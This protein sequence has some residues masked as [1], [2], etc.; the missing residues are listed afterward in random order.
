MA[1][2]QQ[3]RNDAMLFERM[4]N[5]I[6]IEVLSYMT[7][8]NAVIAFSTLN[9]R[10]QSLLIE[11]CHRFNFTSV[12]KK[13]FDI[14]FQNQDTNR[15]RSL[16]LHDG[17]YTPGQVNYFFETHSLIDKFCQLRNL[18]IMKLKPNHPYPLFTQLPSLSNL[19]SL[20][21]EPLCGHNIL[22]VELPNLKK[23]TFSS[24]PN[25]SWLKVRKQIK[26]FELQ[27]IILLLF[28]SC[29]EFCAT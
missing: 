24:C 4:P 1:G 21:I 6:F 19:V 5:E 10:F 15:W 29:I 12:S 3:N 28:Y 8:I 14:V 7:C 18:S 2:K 25:T 17:D 26:L 11:F 13:N 20:E 9:S 16:K 27:R 23:L 22:E